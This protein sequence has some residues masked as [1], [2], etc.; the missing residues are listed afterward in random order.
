MKDNKD[1][2]LSLY[3]FNESNVFVFEHKNKLYYVS[4]M[5]R[6]KMYNRIEKNDLN[7]CKDAIF[8]L[9]DLTVKI[10]EMTNLKKTWCIK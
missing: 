2:L 1:A 9:I 6:F 4:E 7:Y 5:L 8:N 3:S 10:I